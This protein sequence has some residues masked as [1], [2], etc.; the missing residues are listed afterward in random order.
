MLRSIGDLRGFLVTTSEGEIV[1]SVENF[2]FDDEKWAI[3]YLV[4]ETK[5]DDERAGRK[6]LVSPAAV[7]EL[8]RE[9]NVLQLT[10]KKDEILKSPDIDT[11]KPVSR[12]RELE[13]LTHFEWPR[14][15]SGAQLWGASGYPAPYTPLQL[16]SG[17]ERDDAT[18]QT[19]SSA[20]EMDLAQKA[21]ADPHLRSVKEVKSYYIE[22]AD[23]SL[24]HVEDFLVEEGTWAI[25]YIV[26]DTKNW[27]PGKSVLI[28]SRWIESVR[29][30]KTKVYV[31]L[32]RKA[33]R[34]APEFDATKKLS[35]D[36][37]AR[38]H[39]HYRKTPYWLQGRKSARGKRS[40]AA[41]RAISNANAA[42]K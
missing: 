8:I 9:T 12:Q 3:R 17:A 30:S 24:G 38:L 19:V 14:Y 25:R 18:A 2:Y 31:G 27:W 10:L 5:G 15:W 13:V 6:V 28:S 40:K 26:I 22:A 39:K 21:H 32:S 23:G 7:S 16:P 35:R 42:V 29:W 1:A 11:E 36:F 37:E 4:V 41:P 20:N 33:I 34:S